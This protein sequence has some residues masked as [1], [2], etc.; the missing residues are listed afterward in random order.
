MPEQ[1]IDGDRIVLTDPRAIRALAHPARLA[2]IEA[3]TS[4]DELTATECATLTGLSPSATNYHLKALERWGIVKPGRPRADGRDRPWKATGRSVEVG[5]SA[6]GQTALAE[7]A[8]LGTV[9]ERNRS[10]VSEFFEHRDLEPPQW[11]DSADLGVGDY[12][13]T[14][15]ET[16]EVAGALREVLRQYED[17]RRG[18]RP[19]GSRRVRVARLIVPRS[20]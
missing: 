16:R 2:I 18:S 20:T 19:A 15:E 9:L 10:L 3:L 13:L 8:V 6:S 17:R 5:S 1:Q 11:R 7:I 14:A 12:W 4:G